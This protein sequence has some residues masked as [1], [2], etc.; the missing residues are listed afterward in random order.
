MGI[1][2]N[3]SSAVKRVLGFGRNANPLKNLRAYQGALVSRRTSDWMSSQLSADAEIRNSLRKLRDRSR[4]LVRNNPYARQAKRTTQI[5]IVG[6]GMKFQ[7]LVVQQRGGKRDQR[8]N[9]IIEEAWGEWT[10]ADSCDCAGKYSFHQFEWLASGALCESGEAIFRIVRKPFGNSQVPLA[11]QMIESDLLDEEYDGKT[12]NK[13]NEWRN[14][15][16]VDEWGR[17]IRYAILTKHPGDAYYLDYSA[18]RKLH[19][20]IPAEDIIHLFLPERPGQNRGVPWFHSVMADMHQLQ[21]YEEAAVIRAR[22]GASI[23]GFIQNDQ[24]ELIGDD[25]QNNQRIQSFEPGTFRY[26]MP[27]ESVTVPDIDYPSQQYAVSY[28]HL[29]L[30]TI[31][32]V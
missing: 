3:I 18:N 31:L 6:T 30:P 19:I 28:T 2:S 15:V 5:N 17:A 26:L 13:N 10:Q 25:V 9:N 12:L 32:L 29:T 24:G 11:L 22:A 8:V 20:F 4:E 14:G 7:S 21:G 16:E 27:N 23:M 1:R